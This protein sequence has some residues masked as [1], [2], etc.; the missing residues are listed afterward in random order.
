[1]GSN[2]GKGRT[3]RLRHHQK[4]KG[5]CHLASKMPNEQED[6]KT[7]ERIPLK[8]GSLSKATSVQVEI[9]CV[10]EQPKKKPNQ[11]LSR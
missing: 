7:K 9:K 10:K 6:M 4:Y 3:E 11:R 2:R 5:F 8:H 1:M